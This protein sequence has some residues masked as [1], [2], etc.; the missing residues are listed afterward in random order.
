MSVPT[1]RP[2]DADQPTSPG[3]KHP[4]SF[5]PPLQLWLAP[6]FGILATDGT[7]TASIVTIAPRAPSAA[8]RL[9]AAAGPL[10]SS[11]APSGQTLPGTVT[12]IE[13]CSGAVE[14]EEVATE[15]RWVVR[16]SGGSVGRGNLTP[17]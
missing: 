17:D 15:H 14:F 6:A 3:D 16:I 11:S 5:G 7:T 8:M 10:D 4:V 2:G 9:Q 12:L 1:P 13:K